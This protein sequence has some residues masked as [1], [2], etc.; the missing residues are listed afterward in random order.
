[1]SPSAAIRTA[2]RRARLVPLLSLRAALPALLTLWEPPLWLLTSISSR[3][4]FWF[5]IIKVITIV[6]LIILGIILDC[7][8]G[9]NGEYI[10][11]K[12]WREPGAFVQY[13]GIEG[14]TGR[15]LGV[16]AVLI[17]E[18]TPFSPFPMNYRH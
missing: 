10:G 13:M 11:T 5:A 1:M 17:R 7:G 14:A 12:Y 15:F 8:G 2:G 4:R 3:A 18:A 16:W 9:P 6:G